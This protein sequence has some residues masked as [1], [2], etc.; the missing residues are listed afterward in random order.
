VEQTETALRVCVVE[1]DAPMAQIIAALLRKAGHEVEVFLSPT[2]ALDAIPRLKPDVVIT[3]LLMPEVDGL[4]VIAALRKHPD[5]PDLKIVVLSAKAYDYDREDARAAGADGFIPKPIVPDHFVAQVRGCISNA[6]TIRYWGVR[7]TLPVPG[8]DSLR[9]GGNTNCISIEFPRQRNFVFD[10]GTGIKRLGNHV[11]AHRRGKW[12]ATMFISHP[13][14]DHIN[15]FPFFTPL[16]IPG[17]EVEVI[18]AKQHRKTMRELMSAQMDDVYFPIK[19][20]ELGARVF[21]RDIG[22][23]TMHFDDIE[24]RSM[25]LSHPG[26]CL[27]YRVTFAGR[28]FCYI[29]DNEI[30]PAGSPHHNPKFEADL[31]DFMRDA[32]IAVMDATYFAEEYRTKVNWGHSSVDEV[33]RL[34]HGAGVK[35]LH[36]YHHDPD[37]TDAMIDRKLARAEECLAALGSN[38]VCTAPAEGDAIRL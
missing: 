5:L 31:M 15:A 11:M 19:L 33:V 29:T 34:A 20:K 12:S 38:T 21:F 22:P 37:Q 1:D 32:D 16:F 6:V 30:Y 26:K 9:Y 18:G 13:H 7:G 28:V 8:A 27:G 35:Q 2:A 36:L 10:A 24:V 25:L 17:N 14:W 23:E 4:D 3:D